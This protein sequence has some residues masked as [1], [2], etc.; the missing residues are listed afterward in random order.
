MHSCG[1]IFKPDPG[2]QAQRAMFA[3]SAY[4]AMSSGGRIF[5]GQSNSSG[6]P[7][8]NTWMQARG[9]AS[10]PAT[11]ALLKIPLMDAALCRSPASVCLF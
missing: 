8:T 11:T 10:I 5:I 1:G 2:A 7:S 9:I 6:M 3:Y 4:T